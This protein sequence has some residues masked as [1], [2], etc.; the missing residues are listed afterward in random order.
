MVVRTEPKRNLAP[1]YPSAALEALQREY[2]TSPPPALARM[3]IPP[4]PPAPTTQAGGTPGTV[5]NDSEPARKQSANAQPAQPGTPG[6]V[7]NSS[8][9]SAHRQR[10]GARS[11]MSSVESTGDGARSAPSRHGSFGGTQSEASSRAWS[12]PLENMQSDASRRGRSPPLER[13]GL[14]AHGRPEGD[15]RA[16][17]GYPRAEGRYDE[18]RMGEHAWYGGRYPPASREYIDS[19]DHRFI[20][21]PSFP[22]Y[23]HGAVGPYG[24]RHYGDIP[25]EYPREPLRDMYPAPSSPM[26]H[27]DYARE[28]PQSLPG[29]SGEHRRD[30]YSQPPSM[31]PYLDPRVL[32]P[33]RSGRYLDTALPSREASPN[34]R[35]SSSR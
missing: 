7:S 10:T 3:G 19:F 25:R 34:L 6:M 15:Y 23:P 22:P 32:Q 14:E 29:P 33:P 27:R 31:S 21:P 35:P 18:H 24:Y 13:M 5:S 17:P 2:A 4:N 11:V 20:P 16:R 9:D 28:P 12:P 8:D 26:L 30:M 1:L